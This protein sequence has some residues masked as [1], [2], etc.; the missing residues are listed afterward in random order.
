MARF[1]YSA[2]Q[3]AWLR[4]QC[5]KLAIGALTSAFNERFDLVKTEL[6]IKSAMAKYRIIGGRGGKKGLRPRR[7]FTPRQAAFIARMY[8]DISLIELT[9]AVNKKFKLAMEVSQLRSYTRNHGFTSGRSGCFVKGALPWNLNKKG[10][11]GANRTSFGKGNIPGNSKPLGTERI[12][13]KDGFVQVKIA[14]ANPYTGEPTR[15]KHKHVVVWE[16][17]HGPVPKGMVV[18]LID[19]VKTNCVPEN[20]LLVTRAEHLRLNQLGV[21]AYPPELRG[22]VVA[23]AKLEVKA[24]GCRRRQ[25]EGCSG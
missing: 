11:M 22:T 5:S 18:R 4:D 6:A 23:I 12:C 14:E 9:A 16:Q 3:L 21:S 1:K 8:K 2:D 19:G 20:L 15:Y 24:F 7:L 25:K 17:E 13:Q 10:Y